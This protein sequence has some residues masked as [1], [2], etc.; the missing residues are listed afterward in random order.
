MQSSFLF[1]EHHYLGTIFGGSLSVQNRISVVS[2]KKSQSFSLESIDAYRQLAYIELTIRNFKY[3][4]R[5][6]IIPVCNT[7]TGNASKNTETLYLWLNLEKKYQIFI[8]RQ[9]F[10]NIIRSNI[11]NYDSLVR[12]AQWLS[13]W[14]S[15]PIQI[16]RGIRLGLSTS[17][18]ESS[19]SFRTNDNSVSGKN[20]EK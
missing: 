5:I 4:F 1:P 11:I 2:V 18:L 13:Q 10:Y 17:R 16:G 3:L 12:M 8:F 20:F 15:V 19:S 14:P 7:V 6:L 9:F